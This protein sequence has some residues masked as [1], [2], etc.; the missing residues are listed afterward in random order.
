VTHLSS[1][2][3]AVAAATGLAAAVALLVGAASPASAAEEWSVPRDATIVLTGHGYGHGIGMSQHGAEGAARRGLGQRAIMRHYYPGTRAGTVGGV[4]RV[5]ITADTTDD[6]VVLA[7]RGLLVRDLGTREVWTAPRNGATRW[8][9]R[10]AGGRTVV[11][12]FS[13]RWR[14]WRVLE[15]TGEFGAKGAPITLVTPSGSRAYR[16]RLRAAIPTRGST[17]RDTVNLVGMESYLRGVVPLEMPALWSPAAVQAQAV[18]ARTYAAYERQHPRA[19]HHHTCDTTA[20][21][22]YGGVAA[23]HTASDRAI[24]AT[25]REARL[26]DGRPALTMFSSSSGGWTAGASAPY[27]VATRD[28]YDDWAGN[29]VHSWRVRLA[30][31]EVERRFPAIGNLRRIRIL[32]R[33]GHGEWG[34]RVRE[35]VFV[36]SRGRARMSGDAARSR[37]GLRSTWFTVRVRG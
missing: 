1:G 30:D 28:P 27:L 19:R 35:I 5:R 24:A 36:G 8:R 34:G 3:R 17:A 9:I 13:D 26:H 2:R 11:A 37:L 4:M 14:R 15:G 20:C 12:S 21:Q 25:R 16:G 18:A 33:N 32:S 6:V 29:S 23:E 7:R 22:V 31:E 10:V